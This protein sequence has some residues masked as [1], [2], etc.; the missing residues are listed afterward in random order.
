LIPA[1]TLLTTRPRGLSAGRAWQPEMA[2]GKT[3]GCEE[4]G[5]ARLTDSS[6]PDSRVALLF[7]TV[8]LSNFAE[9]SQ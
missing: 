1:L 8:R 4:K 6:P 9:C 7:L 5:K 2:E 3:G